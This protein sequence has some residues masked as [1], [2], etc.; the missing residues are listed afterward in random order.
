M[1]LPGAGT[2]WPACRNASAIDEMLVGGAQWAVEKGYGTK[3][4][5][6]RIEEN[7]KMAGAVPKYV[8]DHAKERQQNHEADSDMNCMLYN[9]W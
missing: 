1:R 7:G 2:S 5:L 3:Q 8:S 9:F 6:G 4:D